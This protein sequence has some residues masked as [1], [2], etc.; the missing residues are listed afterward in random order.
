MEAATVRTGASTTPA[1]EN[2]ASVGPQ[3]LS[4]NQV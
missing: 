2:K 4:Q 3:R 1:E